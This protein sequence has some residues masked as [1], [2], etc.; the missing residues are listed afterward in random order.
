MANEQE[1]R[2]RDNIAYLDLQ[3]K[4]QEE[5]RQHVLRIEKRMTEGFE[6]IADAMHSVAVAQAQSQQMHE[7]T[8]ERLNE[9]DKRVNEN[10][11]KTMEQVDSNEDDINEIKI[12]LGRQSTRLMLYGAFVV[13]LVGSVWAV[14][15]GIIAPAIDVSKSNSEIQKTI[16]EQIKINKAIVEHLKEIE[17]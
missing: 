11:E 8:N 17:K 10:H 1:E 9:L 16:D 7:Y 13:G 12:V 2:R 5:M 4:A 15:Q 6:K 3:A 14:A